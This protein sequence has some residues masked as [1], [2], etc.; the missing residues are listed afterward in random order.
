[1][2]V[3]LFVS[4][5]LCPPPPFI[6]PTP[7]PLLEWS[8]QTCLH[9]GDCIRRRD[10]LFVCVCAIKGAMTYARNDAEIFGTIFLNIKNQTAK[11]LQEQK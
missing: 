2:I 6:G 7:H 10:L 5:H 8:A 3:R 11:Y 1:M 4:E 9:K